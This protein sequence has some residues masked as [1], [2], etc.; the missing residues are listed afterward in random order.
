LSNGHKIEDLAWQAGIVDGEGT[1]TI[2]K[3]WRDGRPSPAFRAI[4][5]V[6]NTDHRIVRP[7]KTW[8]GGGVHPRH[9]KRKEKN[10]KDSYA[11]HCPDS[12]VV[13]FLKAILPYLRGK[14]AQANLLMFFQEHRHDFPR[15]SLG[16]GKGS[17]PLGKQEV[18]FR[19]AIWNRVRGLNTKGRYS[20]S[21][22]GGAL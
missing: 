16:K 7:F 9:E 4:V 10:W 12:Q 8:W 3:Q 22:I 13:T 14:K 5:N 6:T 19:D 17:S 18:Q 20:R 11:W 15:H 2:Q 21:Q 1:I